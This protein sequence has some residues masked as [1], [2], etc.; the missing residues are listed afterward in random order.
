MNKITVNEGLIFNV[1]IVNDSIEMDNVPLALDIFSKDRHTKHFLYQN[2]SFN[3]ELIAIDNAKKELKIK[4]NGSSY[5]VN[6][7]TELDLLLH[8]LGM[9]SSSANKVHQVK[10]PMPGLVLSILVQEGQEIKKGENLLVLEAMKMENII[11]S[12]S[13]GTIKKIEVR[14]GDKIEKNTVLIKFL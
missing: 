2:K 1:D 10:A 7:S 6:I 13:D 5:D 9:D 8:K 14:Q 12:P 3:V 11:K 4:V